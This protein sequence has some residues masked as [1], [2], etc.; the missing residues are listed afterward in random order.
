M[1]KFTFEE[2]TP[3]VVWRMSGWEAERMEESQLAGFVV[4]GERLMEVGLGGDS[5]GEEVDLRMI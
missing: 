3:A 1:I 4:G 2:Y 5:G